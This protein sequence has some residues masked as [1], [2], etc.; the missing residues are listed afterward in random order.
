[1]FLRLNGDALDVHEAQPTTT[2][3]KHMSILF[4]LKI[5]GNMFVDVGKVFFSANGSDLGSI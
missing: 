5:D 1:M 3:R 4:L 2:P